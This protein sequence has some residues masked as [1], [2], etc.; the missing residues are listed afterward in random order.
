MI[1]AGLSQR[2]ITERIRTAA[3]VETDLGCPLLT[4]DTFQLSDWI[5]RG[6]VTPATRAAWHSILSAFYRW[7]STVGLRAD[8]PMAAIRAA[9]RPKRAPRPI[10]DEAM[11]RLLAASDDQELTA[12]LI[13]GGYQGLRVS[14]I[15]RMRGDLIDPDARTVRVRGKG[16]HIV[17]L[18]A[19]PRAEVGGHLQSGERSFDVPPSSPGNACARSPDSVE[20]RF[21]GDV[22]RM[23]NFAEWNGRRHGPSMWDHSVG[24]S[25]PIRWK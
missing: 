5:A 4:A 17:V 16:G 22:S 3:R 9:R 18:P 1:T 7:A 11:R 14:E 2:T 19:H 24:L 15:A 8:N 25:R 6:D 20:E 23:A 10:S 13:L 12:M 21:V